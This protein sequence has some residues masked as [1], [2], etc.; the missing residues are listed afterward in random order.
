MTKRFEVVNLI[1]IRIGIDHHNLGCPIPPEAILMNPID[2]QLMDHPRLWGIPVLSDPSVP[3]KVVRL[4][5]EGS[6]ENIEQELQGHI[7][8]G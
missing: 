1:A 4:R 3:T 5:C 8:G 6:A 2:C 7:Q